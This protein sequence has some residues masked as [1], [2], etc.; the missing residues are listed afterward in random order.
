[1]FYGYVCR[2]WNLKLDS[3]FEF[4]CYVSLYLLRTVFSQNAKKSN[5]GGSC[6]KQL[7]E[8]MERLPSGYR[9]GSQER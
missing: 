6:Q 5:G 8:H 1:M 7:S 3:F 4:E 9:E 2:Y